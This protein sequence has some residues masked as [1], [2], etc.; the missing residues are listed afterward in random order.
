MSQR[1]EISNFL[2]NISVGEY[3][4]AHLNLKTVVEDKLKAKIKK[5]ANKRIF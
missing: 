1:T 5:A 3:K 2:K 4:N